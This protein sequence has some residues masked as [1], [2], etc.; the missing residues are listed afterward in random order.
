M[1]RRPAR[2]M[3]LSLSLLFQTS[4]RVLLSPAQSIPKQII[5]PSQS[6]SRNPKYKQNLMAISDCDPAMQGSPNLRGLNACCDLPSLGLRGR[7]RCPL[8]GTGH[9]MG[10]D[11]GT[12]LI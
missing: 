8:K 7:T 12:Y 4:A 2:P 9:N 10:I 1:D 11:Y 5:L 3:R 6:D